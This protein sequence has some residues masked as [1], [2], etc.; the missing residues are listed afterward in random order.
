ML[1]RSADGV[2]Y[3]TS[4]DANLFEGMGKLIPGHSQSATLW[5]KNP[6]AARAEV[7]LSAADVVTPSADFAASVSISTANSSD[8][9]TRATPLSGLENCD[10]LVDSQS[11]AAGEAIEMTVTFS[12]A[13][14][15]D[16]VAQN[17]TVSLNARVGMR[18]AAAGPFPTS[19]CDD[20]GVVIGADPDLTAEPTATPTSSPTSTSTSTSTSVASAASSGALAHTGLDAAAPLTIVGGLFIGGVLFFLMGRRRKVDN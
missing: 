18:D 11:L 20:G 5:V 6:T 15:S 1:F 10:V 13:D 8:Q 9:V 3:A 16:Q 19:A 4:L 2:H 7:R 14:V 12:M 17:A